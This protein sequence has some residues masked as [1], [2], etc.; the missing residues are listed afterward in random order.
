MKTKLTIEEKG[1]EYSLT[2][3]DILKEEGIYK[4]ESDSLGF[5][6]VINKYNSSNE[7][8]YL[9]RDGTLKLPSVGHGWNAYMF[10]KIKG[11]INIT[12]ND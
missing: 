5:L 10:R 9:D 3:K 1:K 2:F 4:P 12:L 7:I 11:E 8:I 6:L